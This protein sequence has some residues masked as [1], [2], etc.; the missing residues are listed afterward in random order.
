MLRSPGFR[1]STTSLPKTSPEKISAGYIQRMI[2]VFVGLSIF[3]VG[4]IFL[5]MPGSEEHALRAVTEIS[6]V[7]G[8][9]IMGA[10]GVIGLIQTSSAIKSV[11]DQ[12]RKDA[13]Q[14][15]VMAASLIENKADL[16]QAEK[17]VKHSV[18]TVKRFSLF[19]DRDGN[20]DIVQM[21]LSVKKDAFIGCVA[22]NATAKVA[23][24][25][26]DD[27]NVEAREVECEK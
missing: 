13:A 24:D 5:M 7:V 26:P 27:I 18:P 3:I 12:I 15:S 22:R 21:T 1:Y 20:P 23:I 2:I 14:A 11:E 6:V 16:D 17:T 10:G 25:R 9:L 8:F 4:L 19:Y